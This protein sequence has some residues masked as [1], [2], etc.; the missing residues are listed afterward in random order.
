MICQLFAAF[1]RE[2]MVW[3]LQ[4]FYHDKWKILWLGLF[5]LY[6]NAFLVICFWSAYVI[7][8][9]GRCSTFR[10]PTKLP[11]LGPLAGT[12]VNKQP[13]TCKCARA[14]DPAL[15]S[16]P[17]YCINSFSCKYIIFSPSWSLPVLHLK[18]KFT[19]LGCYCS[20]I[21]DWLILNSHFVILVF[22]WMLVL[23]GDYT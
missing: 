23:V 5:P 13:N 16:S 2:L 1:S 6:F 14:L 8:L 21:Y 10:I 9:F 18:Q 7:R 12:T 20:V 19:T 22:L 4:L 15:D 3:F 11:R 17:C